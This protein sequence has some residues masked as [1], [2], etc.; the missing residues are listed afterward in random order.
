MV[1]TTEK[2]AICRSRISF[3]LVLL[4]GLVTVLLILSKF[5]DGFSFGLLSAISLAFVTVEGFIQLV[6]YSSAAEAAVGYIYSSPLLGDPVYHC[7]SLHP[8]GDG[9]GLSDGFRGITAVAT[10]AV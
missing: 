2:Q 8:I 5:F 7:Q 9:D 4:S 1:S 10:T 6:E 3:C